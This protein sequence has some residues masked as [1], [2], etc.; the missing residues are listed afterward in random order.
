[1]TE[2]Y[3]STDI[4]ADGPIPGEFSM[5]SFASVALKPGG[6]EVGNFKANLEVLPD[7]ARDMGTMK[8]WS[9]HQDAYANTRTNLE[10]PGVAM[11]RY[12]AWLEEIS[13]FGKPVFV[14]YPASWDFSFIY[15]YLIKFTGKSPFGI[16]ALDLKTVGMTILGTEFRK[17]VKA[18]MPK[19]WFEGAPRHTHDP[20]DDAREQGVLWTSMERIMEARNARV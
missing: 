2:V 12:T 3:I 16:S 6:K 10:D 19:E 13:K 14:G 7:A 1:M 5:L 20:L 9:Q 11:P 18:K 8:W 17:T 4:E 15:W